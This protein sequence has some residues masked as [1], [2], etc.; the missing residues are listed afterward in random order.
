MV[1]ARNTAVAVGVTKK[2]H[3]AGLRNQRRSSKLKI[4]TPT[5]QST[6]KSGPYILSLV[7]PYYIP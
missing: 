6:N 7:P 3:A 1:L 4:P 5:T 2:G